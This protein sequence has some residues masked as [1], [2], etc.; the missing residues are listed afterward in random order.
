MAIEF[1]TLET[2]DIIALTPRFAAHNLKISAYTAAYKIMWNHRFSLQFAE[3]ADCI[4]FSEKFRGATWFHYPLSKDDENAEINAVSAV[5]DYCRKNGVRLHWT[6]V[7]RCKLNM[8]VERYGADL[9]IK[10]YLKWRD[11]LYNA[12]DFREYA[13]KKFS[14]QRNHVNKFKKLYPQYKFEI[15]TGANA[16]EIREFFKEY[17]SKQLAKG[18]AIAKAEMEAA[19]RLLPLMDKIGMKAGGIYIGGKLAS[20]AMGEVCGDTLMVDIEK[21]LD[22]EGIYPAT[23]QEFARAFTGGA[24]KFIN[25][26]DDA[27]DRGLRKS[28][29]Q[30]NPVA[31]LDKYNLTPLRPIDEMSEIPRIKSGRIELGE[32]TEDCLDGLFRLETDFESN[33]YWGYDWRNDY[34]GEDFPAPE[35]FLKCKRQIFA[36]REEAPMG[37]FLE[38]KLIG[39]AVLHNFGYNL[40]CEVGIRLLPEYRKKGYAAEA[41]SAAAD[42]AFF[43]LNIDRVTAKCFKENEDSRKCLTAAGMRENGSDETYIYFYKTPAS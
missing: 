17:E 3:V 34:S 8:L 16:G 22:F 30:Y 19:F 35:Y 36:C 14:G 7:P 25:R 5:E 33:K 26:E 38:G 29:L 2:E 31:R 40:E 41:V 43:E 10:S 12:G 13:G 42:Y 4:V 24:V 23:A 20:V 37:V 39:E 15:L 6:N 21:A 27:G 1:K 11:Y 32:F 28:K 18:T 9:H